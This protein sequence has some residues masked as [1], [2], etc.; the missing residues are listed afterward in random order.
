MLRVS[1]RTTHGH[2]HGVAR[3]IEDDVSDA[4]QVGILQ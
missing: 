4:R 1:S 2:F 3:L